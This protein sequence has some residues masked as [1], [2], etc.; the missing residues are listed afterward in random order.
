MPGTNPEQQKGVIAMTRIQPRMQIFSQA[1]ME[2]IF[3]RALWIL[4]NVGVQVICPDMRQR[5]NEQPG[6]KCDGEIVKLPRELVEQALAT[7][8]RKVDVFNRLGEQAFS[9]GPDFN[10]YT[11]FSIG[12]PQLYYQDPVSR[13]LEE[14]TRSH[15][16]L[17]AGLA[18]SLDAFDAIATPGAVNDYGPQEADYYSTLEMMAKTTKPIILLVAN[19]DEFSSILKFTDHILNGT[20]REKPCILPYLNIITPLVLGKGTTDKMKM[21]NEYNLPVVFMNYAMTG[22]TAPISPDGHLTLIVAELLMGITCTQLLKEGAQ[23][24]AG[25]MANNFD[26]STMTP[27]YAPKGMLVSHGIAEMMDFFGVPHVGTSGNNLGW[28]GDVMHQGMT[29]MNH[30]PSLMGKA[31]LCPFAGP[32]FQC[33]TLSATGI[34]LASEVIREARKYHDGFDLGEESTLDE[35]KEVGAGGSY[36][37]TQATFKRFREFQPDTS[38]FPYYTPQKWEEAGK[39][40]A[41]QVLREKTRELL[42]NP[43]VPEDCDEILEK[44]AQYIEKLGLEHP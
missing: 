10:N 16:G 27:F 17:I 8:P 43:K 23:I 35:I 31:G 34:V 1:Q 14:W 19:D 32:V 37:G 22:A 38:V 41:T 5:F 11:R 39:P 30:L 21:A 40:T 7:T 29:W 28:E 3:D 2:E 18:N 6:V 33:T 20:L 13:E 9:L 24:I 15:T 12:S 42:D 25:G 36:F 4:K 26:M 44:G